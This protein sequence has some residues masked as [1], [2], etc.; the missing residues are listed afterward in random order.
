MKLYEA[1]DFG[2]LIVLAKAYSTGHR[3]AAYAANSND[4]I[5]AVT[6]TEAIRIRFDRHGA[7]NDM[8]AASDDSGGGVTLI[9]QKIVS[10]LTGT[11]PVDPEIHDLEALR[12]L[13]NALLDATP[14]RL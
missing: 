8:E 13:A 2:H 9:N 14:Q 10:L 7:R 12:G 3:W 5:T 1:S 4:P 6:L 11:M